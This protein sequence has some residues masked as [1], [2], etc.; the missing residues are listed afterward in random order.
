MPVDA[1]LLGLPCKLCF[2]DPDSNIRIR[3]QKSG[4]LLPGTVTWSFGWSTGVFDKCAIHW[5][6]FY[7]SE[8]PLSKNTSSLAESAFQRA[9]ESHGAED[10]AFK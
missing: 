5:A 6:Y 8:G 9:Q 1:S 10:I 3:L 4:M 2:R 7:S